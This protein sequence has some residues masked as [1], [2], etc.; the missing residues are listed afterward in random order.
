MIAPRD[1]KFKNNQNEGLRSI[2][3]RKLRAFIQS[4]TCALNDLE[5]FLNWS[6][7][8]PFVA[9]LGGHIDLVATWPGF[10][11]DT[12]ELS[13]PQ[14][15]GVTPTKSGHFGNAHSLLNDEC[16]LRTGFPQAGPFLFLYG[17]RAGLICG[18]ECPGHAVEISSR[19]LIG[20]RL[21]IT[22]SHM[23]I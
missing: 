16:K 22:S 6:H 13:A 18:S 23:C 12:L 9:A 4:L 1:C 10:R 2:R 17:A 3:H 8:S 5:L 14:P 7:P 19:R 11:R 15:P 21:R 20:R